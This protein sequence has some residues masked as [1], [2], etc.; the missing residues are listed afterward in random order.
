[1]SQVLIAPTVGRVV[2]FHP[3]ANAA[4][5]GFAR[6]EAGTPLAAIVARVWSDTCV[7][8]TVFDANGAPHSRTSVLVVQDGQP[9]PDGYYCEWMPFQKGQA[10]V[11][12]EVKVYSDGTTVTGPGPLPA[13]SPA[14][15]DA[16]VEQLI[17]AKGKTAPRVTPGDLSANIIDTEI[18]KH[19]SHSGQILRWAVLTTQSGF[20]VTG[21]PSAAVSAENDAS[22]IGVA[23]AIENARNELWP[24]MGYALKQRVHDL[25]NGPV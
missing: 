24:L 4:E 22:E 14:Q 8:L 21:R 3:A 11:Q 25:A 7:N 23:T 15:Q 5:A 16:A 9:V 19:V 13:L 18:V 12:N 2:W 20:A 1:M 17:Q 6:P 10:K